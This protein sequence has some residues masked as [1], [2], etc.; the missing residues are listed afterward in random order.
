V[1][2]ACERVNFGCDNRD[3]EAADCGAN[4]NRKFFLSLR[5]ISSFSNCIDTPSRVALTLDGALE[6]LFLSSETK[7]LDGNTL[8]WGDRAA[9][10]FFT[11]EDESETIEN[12]WTAEAAKGFRAEDFFRKRKAGGC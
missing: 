3:G 8:W 2:L 7:T 4:L 10:A 1:L 9:R 11:V 12:Q 6:N 5:L